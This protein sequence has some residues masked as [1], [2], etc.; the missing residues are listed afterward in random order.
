MA[1]QSNRKRFFLNKNPTGTSDSVPDEE[2]ARTQTKGPAA[3]THFKLEY[4]LAY[5]LYLLPCIPSL[6]EKQANCYRCWGFCFLV[7]FLRFI[8][9]SNW[10]HCHSFV[11]WGVHYICVI[12]TWP[13][14]L[15]FFRWNKLFPDIG[16]GRKNPSRNPD[17]HMYM[18]PH[19][20]TQTRTHSQTLTHVH[21]ST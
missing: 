18:H 10:F 6:F 3:K 17:M 7:W 14:S 8:K 9:W 1:K 21:T 11:K 12:K 5:R 16:Q 13:V 20:H 19:P 4:L 2:I 15:T